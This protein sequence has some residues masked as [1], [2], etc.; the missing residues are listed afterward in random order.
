MSCTV[1]FAHIVP[2][3]QNLKRMYLVLGKN[4]NTPIQAII[5]EKTTP[6]AAITKVKEKYPKAF[7]LTAKPITRAKELKKHFIGRF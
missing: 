5:I 6:S 4:G 1:C 2:H 3:F 7:A